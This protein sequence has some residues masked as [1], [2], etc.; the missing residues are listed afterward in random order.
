MYVKGKIIKILRKRQC[1]TFQNFV[2]LVTEY[3]KGWEL[4]QYHFC[5][6]LTHTNK[7]AKAFY[8]RTIN[9]KNQFSMSRTDAWY[10][11]EEIDPWSYGVAREFRD[12]SFE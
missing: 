2:C 11:T 10:K 5:L 7:H 9:K 1:G 3:K 12:P 4:A 6:L 8:N